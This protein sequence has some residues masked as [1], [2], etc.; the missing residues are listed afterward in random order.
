MATTLSMLL[1]AVDT[2]GGTLAG[3]H[4]YINSKAIKTNSA[5]VRIGGD[6]LTRVSGQ[7]AEIAKLNPADIAASYGIP[8]ADAE[9][10]I[11]SKAQSLARTLAGE[12]AE[13]SDTRETVA[14]SSGGRKV[15]TLNKA[16]NAIQIHCYRD[17]DPKRDKSTLTADD[18]T[19]QQRLRDTLDAD[20]GYRCYSLSPWGP[21]NKPGTENRKRK[22]G[23]VRY[24]ANFERFTFAGL[25]IVPSDIAAM[26]EEFHAQKAT[27]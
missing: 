9:D 12:Q 27:A 5:R 15:V 4:G 6:Y 3:V 8:V 18:R 21:I 13:R 24:G 22:H 10:L 25:T 23:P 1:A 19:G 11:N 7:I 26:V 16:G 2:C 20:T 14:K 17:S